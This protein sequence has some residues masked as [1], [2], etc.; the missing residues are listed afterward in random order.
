MPFAIR[1]TAECLD[2]IAAEANWLSA[3]RSSALADAWETAA[4]AEA[5]SL[6]DMPAARPLCLDPAVQ[7][8]GLREAYFGAG[9]TNTHRLIFRVRGGTVQILNVRGFAQRDLTPA[10]LR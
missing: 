7:G 3:A 6:V 9:K 10:D 5:D 2:K 1:F 4:F 8:H